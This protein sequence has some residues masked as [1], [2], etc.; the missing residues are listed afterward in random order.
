MEAK[1][2]CMMEP[3]QVYER[4]GETIGRTPLV[5][6]RNVV[7]EGLCPIYAKIESRNPGFSVKDRAAYSMIVEA[8]RSGELKPGMGIVEPTSGNTGIGLAVIGATKGYKVTVVMPESMSVERRRV[9]KACG[10]TVVLTEGKKGMKGAI[11]RAEELQASG[12]YWMAKQFENPA[13]PL[14]H[15]R[16]TGPEIWEALG[17]KLG[18]VVAGVGTGGTISGIMHYMRA[19]GHKEVAGVAVEPA[20]S[21]IITQHLKGEELRPGPHKIQGI[22][23]NFIPK[24]LDL[25]VVDSVE[26]V[27][28]D[29]AVAMAA[30]IGKE[31][32]ILCGISS[33][34]AAIGA[35]KYAQKMGDKTKAIVA[36]FP[37]SAERYLSGGIID[38]EMAKKINEAKAGDIL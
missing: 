4:N 26:T 30:R 3:L 19:N 31:E 2:V 13:N 17:D 33:A 14:A 10:A 18:A 5:R 15:E 34:A 36:I 12:D 1:R 28:G 9:M 7:P 37:D 24:N 6:L 22:G 20:E 23:A 11:E 38:A 21:A 29:E 16:T 27:P 25:S 35:I 32:G 8:E